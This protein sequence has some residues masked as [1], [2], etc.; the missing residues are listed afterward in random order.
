MLYLTQYS[1]T[2]CGGD[3][4]YLYCKDKGSHLLKITQFPHGVAG[5]QTLTFGFQ[6]LRYWPLCSLL[7]P[8]S[9]SELYLKFKLSFLST[10]FLLLLEEQLKKTNLL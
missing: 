8:D 6:L 9:F 3:H 1:K 10:G 5:A 7:S 4:Y 2:F